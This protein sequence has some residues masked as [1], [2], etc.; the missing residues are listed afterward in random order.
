MLLDEV[1][2]EIISNNF[3]LSNHARQHMGER[4]VTR[5]D[6]AECV[7]SAKASI[8][9]DKFIFDGYDCDGVELKVVCAYVDVVLIITVY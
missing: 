4:N 7:G 2:D 3:R 8:K 5:Q 6:I 9:E 1:R